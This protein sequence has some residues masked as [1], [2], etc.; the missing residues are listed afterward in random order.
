MVEISVLW[1]QTLN[2]IRNSYLTFVSI[3]KMHIGHCLYYFS[4]GSIDGM[5]TE[6][7]LG[8]SAHLPFVLIWPQ[9]LRTNILL[10]SFTLFINSKITLLCNFRSVAL[11]GVSLPAFQYCG[12][13]QFNIFNTK[14]S[15]SGL[16]L[17]DIISITPQFL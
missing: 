8:I 9:G 14:G 5:R 16:P 17:S 15:Y 6:T 12:K 10:L 4:M 1:T 11:L 3:C 13:S 2:Q 7:I